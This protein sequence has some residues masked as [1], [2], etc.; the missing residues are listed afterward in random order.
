MAMRLPGG[1]QDDEAYW[2]LLYH[3]SDARSP[4]PADRYTASS[5][6]TALGKKGA[7][8]TQHGYFLTEDLGTLD[9]SFFSMTKSDLEKTDPQQ[10]K[11]LEVTRE[12]LESAGEVDYRGKAIG[13]YVGT[14]GEDWLHSQSKENQ[15]TGTFSGSVDLL[16]ANRVSYEF[17]FLGPSLVIKTGCSASLVSLHEA[18]R[19]L[20]NGDCSAAIVAGT[21]LIMGPYLTAAMTQQ[22]VL[23]PEGSCK[24]FDISADGFARADAINAIYIKR[25]DD[26]IRDGNPIRAVIRGTSQNADGKSASLM[27]PSGE[28]HYALMRKVYEEAHLDPGHT[29]FVE[30]HGTGTATGDPI[31]T[32]A[33]G[34]VFGE[35]GVYIGSVKPNIGHAEGASG[36]N[37]LIKCVLML[38]RKTILPQI[39]FNTPNPKIPFAEKKLKVPLQPTPWPS[40]RAERVSINSFGIGGSNAHV[41]LDSLAQAR[42]D[43]VAKAATP[44]RTVQPPPSLIVLSANTQESLKKHIANTQ[45]YLASHED[46]KLDIAYTLSQRR[47]HLPYR[48]YLIAGSDAIATEAPALVKAPASAAPITMVFSGQGAQW[49]EMGKDLIQNDAE[50]RK[51]IQAMD[52][53]L[54]SLKHPPTWFIEHELQRPAATS[55]LARAE[56]AQPLCTAVQVALFNALSRAGIAPTAVVGHSSGE[57]AAAYATGA[58]SMAEAVILAYYRGYVTKQ[59]TLVGGMAAVGLG[60]EDVAPF[61]V[62]GVVVACENS[63]NSTTISGDKDRLELVIDAIKA[64]KPDVL[65]RQLKVDMAYHSHHMYALSET[66]VALVQAELE[67]K[68]ITRTDP[69]IPLYST[70]HN[71]VIE[72]AFLLNPKYWGANLTSPVRF[73][74]A[75]ARILQDRPQTLFVEVGPHS[76]LAGPLR[77]ICGEARVPC[78]YI[79]TM[80]RA[81]SCSESLLAAY[82]QLFQ[83]GARVDFGAVMPRGKVVPGLP[84]YPWD[85]SQS[86]WV[87]SRISRDWRFRAFGHHATLGQRIPEST[88]FDPSWRVIIDLEDEPWLADH[89]V[90]DDI[91]FPFA[92]YVSMAGEAIRQL[93]GNEVGY[94]VRHV[95]AHTALV[96]SASKNVEVVTTLRR[97]K[98]TDSADSDAY[99][100][101]ISSWS[102]STW[103]KNCE[104]VVKPLEAPMA[105]TPTSDPVP[106]KASAAKWYEIMARV[107]LVYG[108]EFQGIKSL[109]ASTTKQLATGLITSPDAHR[110]AAF[111]FHPAGI[112]SCL[113][114]ML[115][116]RAQAAGRH[117][118]Q[119]AVPTLIEELDIAHSAPEMHARGWYLDDG[120]DVGLDCVADGKVVMRLRG[121][122]LTPLEDERM[123][124]SNDRHAAARLEW[125]PDFDFMDPAPL[126]TAP[127]ATN[128][129][130][131][132]VEELSLLCQLDSHERL[133][134]LTT[135]I[136][137]FYKFREW[138][139]REKARCESGDYPIVADAASYAR[140]TRAERDARIRQKYAELCTESENVRLVATGLLRIRDNAEALFRG[141]LDTLEMLM[142]DN[143]L[144]EIYDAVS[145]GFGDFVRMLAITKPN[146]RVL[147][148]GAGTG[149][150]TE[151]LLRSLARCGGNPSYAQYM[152]TD[153]SAG[154]FSQ[155]RERFS[156][157]PNMDY[158]VFDISQDPFEQGFA[159]A[160]YDL[161]LAPNVVHATENLNTTLRNLQVLLKPH[162]HLVLSEVCALARVPG[163]VFG[164]FSGWW[165]G[166]ADNRKWEPYI[167]VDRWDAELRATGFTGVDTAVYDAEEPYQYCAAIISQPVLEQSPDAESKAITV[168][169]AR[170]DDPDPQGIS[171]R[172]VADLTAAGFSVAVCSLHDSLPADRDV[173]STIDLETRFFENISERDY[174][175]FQ[176]LLRELR[177]HQGQ[178]VLWLLPPSQVD[179][180]DPRSAQILG[181]IRVARAELAIAVSSL[182][183]DVAE[184]DFS[185][186]VQKVF[187]KVRTRND[188]ESIAP[189]REFIVQEGVIKIGRYQPFSLEDEV[190]EKSR[191]AAESSSGGG[192][193]GLKT[194]DITKPGL[195]ETL[196][197]AETSR[198]EQLGAHDVEIESRAAGMNFRDIMVAMGVLTFGDTGAALGM[199]VSGVVS[200]VGPRVNNVA[201]GDRVCGVAM[202]GCFATHAVLLDDLVRKIPDNLSF[203]DG[204][205][206]PVCYTTAV[207]ALFDVG[208]LAK[209]QTILIHSACGG[210][211]HAAIELAKMAGADIYCTVGSD[212]K[213]EY[214]VEKMGIANDHIFNSRNTSFLPDVMR[215]THGRGVDIVLNSL[216]GELLHASW[217][218]VAEFGKLVELG[219]RDLVGFGKLDLEPF[220]ANRSYCCVDLAH[221]LRERAPYVGELMQRWLDMYSKGHIKGIKALTSFEPAEIEQCFRYLQKGD[222]IGKAI[223]RFPSDAAEIP[224]V[225]QAQ[226]FRFDPEAAYLF[227]GG[228]GGLGRSVAS[229]AVEHGA[230]HLIFLSRS[231]GKGEHDQAFFDELKSLDCHATAVAG[232]ADSLADVKACIR[233][234]WRPIRG[235][236]HM[237][238]VL[239]DTPILDLTY[240]DWTAAIKPK[241]D[242]AWNLHEA[243]SDQQP[244]LDFFVM[245]SSIVT[246]VDQPG[247]SNYAA[248]NTFLESFCQYRH[249]RGLP[250][251]VLS[252]C[253]IDDIGFVAENPSVR[254][255]LKSQGMYFLPERDL[256]DY[257]QLAILNSH[258]PKPTN[259]TNPTITSVDTDTDLTKTASWKAES[260]IVMGLRSEIHLE[261]PA[262]TTS[263]R[264][265]RRMGMYHNIPKEATGEATSANANALKAF[266][267]RAADDVDVLKDSA[268][269]EFLATEIGLRIF[270]FMMKPEDD[271]DIAMSLA[272]IGLDSLMAIELRRWWKQA[273]GLDISVLEIMG[274]GTLKELGKVAADALFGKLS[275]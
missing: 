120:K 237:A 240:A 154:F 60:R 111:P 184:S 85:H 160:S 155:A 174:L 78:S 146:L 200:R 172:L 236:F 70:V 274:S 149:G 105:A 233:K 251:S 19:A 108:P 257:M 224:S 103:I 86:F 161:I 28:A 162:G 8:K 79:A 136:P 207:Q 121:A 134:G 52:A 242:G 122:R 262:C 144:T 258:P 178:K 32:T 205:A 272:Q 64:D 186:L 192:P 151:L 245:T 275:G 56:F 256:L 97:H 42:P 30:C 84:A 248:A 91:V 253:P 1:I 193:G 100:F 270:R 113:Q 188:I 36:L 93:S 14:F 218:C 44:T 81:R 17:D 247:Q 157:A 131:R 232:R 7:I 39:K 66:Y 75:V 222:H 92:G 72:H 150:T 119:L 220:L 254:R 13:C 145:F 152:F 147:E 189:D 88:A 196:H 98:L 116:A 41:I 77:Q 35:K 183:I 67:A 47:E 211:G 227:T 68:N 38:E 15:F 175:R 252:V 138:L 102:G 210:I 264:R 46:E 168:L 133:Q 263:W 212:Y 230:R 71:Q 206:M 107:G 153:I 238:M 213:R 89:K 51:D 173:I 244:P 165:L 62:D 22:G 82:G 76:T 177:E 61:L 181:M 101:V 117:F 197:W 55:Q 104:G 234:S 6:S 126:F 246:T 143:V 208:Q 112:D 124:A 221:A 261:D 43:L 109:A 164:H 123:A 18:C 180:A 166:E 214:L 96:L 235:V 228:L 202:E 125:Y 137:H 198:K 87:E 3:G 5:F 25:L 226:D 115:A 74:P 191:L 167:Q 239:R 99:D 20:Q 130:K 229:W 58:L 26:A 260:H 201:V 267:A 249:R 139:A 142:A 216:S 40:D 266:L 21:S 187:Q 10:R 169:C 34:D 94:S 95:V 171:R 23:S 158:K 185:G 159:P 59:Q 225:S 45:A 250:A 48:A 194:L 9:A 4:I 265:D 156:Y 118:T 11:I 83:Q 50:F 170:P 33:V 12:C 16:I 90:R 195:L 110:Q 73:H 268:S 243:F 217:K 241:V 179:C 127:V 129:L 203:E 209:G 29:A 69:T 53:I 80:L 215:A 219:K 31:E 271:M 114:L 135:D 141:E 269:V 148:V 176:G 106:R 63:P 259:P 65:A 199:E 54:Q 182:E 204:A 190:A 128:D 255:K 132:R 57:I 2:D 223:V 163:Y 37:S 140:L 49:P 24:S 231:A 273:F 27:A